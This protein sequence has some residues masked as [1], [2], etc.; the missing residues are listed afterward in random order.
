MDFIEYNVL[1]SIN[2]TNDY[3]HI[4][5]FDS[6]ILYTEVISLKGRQK[7]PLLCIIQWK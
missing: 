1:Q 2:Q 3:F 4:S 7:G 5:D 6:N